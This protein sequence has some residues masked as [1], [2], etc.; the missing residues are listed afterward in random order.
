[1][2]ESIE[3]AAGVAAISVGSLPLGVPLKS[4]PSKGPSTVLHADVVK[5]SEKLISS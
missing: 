1:M 3:D 5:A 4:L 2:F